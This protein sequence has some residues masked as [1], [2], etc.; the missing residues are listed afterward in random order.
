MFLISSLVSDLK[1]ICLSAPYISAACTC[2]SQGAILENVIVNLGLREFA[3]GL[4][5]VAP[6]R[7]RRIENLYFDPMPTHPR[8]KAMAKTK[9][10]AARKKQDE[11]ERL[12]DEKYVAEANKDKQ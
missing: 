4:T 7:V 6:T 3:A 12:S 11:R 2:S 8:L 10:F 1:E 9:I 5:Y